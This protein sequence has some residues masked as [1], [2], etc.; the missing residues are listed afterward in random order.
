MPQ[1]SGMDNSIQGGQPEYDLLGT[2]RQHNML[3]SA[4]IP[5]SAVRN[6]PTQASLHPTLQIHLRRLKPHRQRV[7]PTLSH[8]LASPPHLSCPLHSAAGWLSNLDPI[9]AHRFSRDFG[10]A[11]KTLLAGVSPGRAASGATAWNQWVAFTSDLGIDPFLQTFN[12]K[13]PFLDMS[14][15][16]HCN[17]CNH[18]YTLG[19]PDQGQTL[20]VYSTYLK[21][22]IRYQTN[23]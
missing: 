6:P 12:D 2:Q 3:L 9:K 11:Q 10:V 7:V 8:D 17:L 20:G 1:R 18:C 13:I 21:Y 15:E 16:V 4:G 22:I 5:P 14:P 23:F 19:M